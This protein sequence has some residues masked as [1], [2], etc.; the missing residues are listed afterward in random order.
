[1]KR[2][3]K[4]EKVIKDYDLLIKAGLSEPRFC[5]NCRREIRAYRKKIH[6]KRSL[7]REWKNVKINRIYLELSKTPETTKHGNNKYIF[8]AGG[9]R[10]GPT[11]WAGVSY[12]ERYLFFVAPQLVEKGKIKEKSIV[13]IR[14]ML[15]VWSNLDLKEGSNIYFV[16]EPSMEENPEAYLDYVSGY[17]KT[18]LAGYG[19]DRDYREHIET[20]DYVE[21]LTHNTT[22]ARSGRFG[23]YVTHYVIFSKEY[24]IEPEGVA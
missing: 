3:E 4:C 9:R 13:N 20:E 17:Y 24:S 2:C 21:E 22:S 11:S 23:N 14:K 7:L 16:I 12:N 8:A 6:V 18:T 15:K 5:E 1:M 19:R 10:F